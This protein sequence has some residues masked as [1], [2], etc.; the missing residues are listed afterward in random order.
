MNYHDNN[1]ESKYELPN[2]STFHLN[3]NNEESK[4]ELPNFSSFQQ[5][6]EEI[7]NELRFN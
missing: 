3:N 5:I 1:E 6:D 2:F 7:S 4:Y